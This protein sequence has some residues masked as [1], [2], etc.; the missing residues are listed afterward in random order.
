[1]NTQS[2]K[3]AG[4]LRI[5]LVTLILVLSAGLAGVAPAGSVGRVSVTD[6]D[7][8]RD[9]ATI[10]RT[11]AKNRAE[12]SEEDGGSGGFS[13][14][15]GCSDLNIGNVST[16]VGQRVPRNVT[17]VIEGPVIQENKCR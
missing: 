4:R 9:A 16:G 6:V 2:P 1:M 12:S 17:I 5:A 3:Q 7:E 8:V 11:K 13:S 10:A 14:S 15:G